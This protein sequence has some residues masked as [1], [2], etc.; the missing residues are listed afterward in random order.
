MAEALYL[1]YNKAY[2]IGIL[3]HSYSA[4]S[5]FTLWVLGINTLKLIGVFYLSLNLIRAIY[6][7]IKRIKNRM[8]GR[9][10]NL[11]CNRASI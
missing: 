9:D 6:L 3:Y 5:S 10:T 4:V 7:Y 8:H 11:A 1:D 2:I